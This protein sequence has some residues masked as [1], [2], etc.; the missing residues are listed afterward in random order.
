MNTV[1][2]IFEH[3]AR[4]GYVFSGN[5]DENLE[6]FKDNR[7]L[8]VEGSLTHLFVLRDMEEDFGL[9]P[10]PKFNEQQK[11]YSSVIAPGQLTA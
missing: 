7:G 1:Q 10:L 4:S 9:L 3:V 11:E 8:F 5:E 6:I 2:Y